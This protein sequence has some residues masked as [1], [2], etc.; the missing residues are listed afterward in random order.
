VSPF[1]PLIRDPH[2]LTVIANF[3]PVRLDERRFPVERRLFAT[4]P[5]VQVLVLSQR[6][7]AEL[8]GDAVLVHG[9][10]GS[11]RSRYMRSM[12]RALLQAG[13]AV[14][15][16]HMRTCG[17][18]E[19]LCQTFYHA[20]LTGDLLQVLQ[21]FE[22]WRR[23]PVHLIGFSLGGNVAL[24]L[25]G[26][27]EESGGKYL[28][29][30][31]AVST[32]IDL[33]ASAQRIAQP[34]NRLYERRFLR[35]MARRLRTR[36]EYRFASL[37]G[38][39]SVRDFDN[40]FTAPS[41]GFRSAEDYYATQSSSRFLDAIQVPA[42]LVQA[43]DDTFIPFESFSHPAFRTNPHLKLLATEHGGH[44]GFIARRGP[45]FWLENVIVE[46]FSRLEQRLR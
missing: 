17:G 38:V 2:L 27:L 12:A 29:A 11:A 6:P 1:D 25:A 20:G 15:R 46:W 37:H 44:V 36:P 32:P 4:E 31:C 5:G 40:R 41:F 35:A 45:R 22:S 18:T 10:E 28:S 34:D 43:K 19:H 24:K 16:F 26:E 30:V 21:Q 9:L 33:A 42:L 23:T 3:W 39:R 13:Y 7:Q 14:H 8:R